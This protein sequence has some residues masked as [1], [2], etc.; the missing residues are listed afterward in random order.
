MIVSCMSSVSLEEIAGR[1]EHPALWFQTYLFSD[2]QVTKD[3]VCRAR[4]AN[5]KAIVLTIGCPVA[6]I[7]RRNIRNRFALPDGVTAANFRRN[8][9]TVHNNPIHSFQGAELDATATWK[10]VEWLRNQSDLPVLLKGLMNPADVLPAIEA[11]A[12]GV[13]VSNHGGRQLDGTEST[14][15]ALPE[16]VAAIDRRIWVAIDSGFR[17]ATDIVKGLALGADAVFLGRPVLWA[18][19]AGGSQGVITAMGTLIEELK[20]A[21]QL[22]GCRS[23]AD[24]RKKSP[25]LVR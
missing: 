24:L 2:R 23:V 16:I 14:I 20:V 17:G 1:S 3:L 13:I 9:T 25:L 10:D 15:A 12:S 11:G 19:A 6:G 4:E 21:M 18:L 5:Y 8:E 7:R 22:L